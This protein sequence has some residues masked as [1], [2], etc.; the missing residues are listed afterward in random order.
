MKFEEM[1]EKFNGNITTPTEHEL[2][3]HWVA[4]DEDCRLMT[5]MAWAGWFF[6]I[7]G[8]VASMFF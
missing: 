3:N 4:K 6:A 2:W 7:A 5:A 1:Q 8:S